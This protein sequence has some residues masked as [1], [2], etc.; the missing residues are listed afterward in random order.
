MAQQPAPMDVQAAGMSAHISVA[1]LELQI[2]K[3]EE[4]HKVQKDIDQIVE[5]VD[6]H[7]N[8]DKVQWNVY[9]ERE[10][11]LREEK[12]LLMKEK[13]QLM[14]SMDKDMVEVIN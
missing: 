8:D 1:S 7:C 13:Q 4:L 6:T 14:Q 5:K 12:Q 11:R 9:V 10:R 3:N 2:R